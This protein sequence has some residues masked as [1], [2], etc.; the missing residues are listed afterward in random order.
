MRP[1]RE[2]DER[3]GAG[4]RSSARGVVVACVMALACG[5]QPSLAQTPDTHAPAGQFRPPTPA[6]RFR[7]DPSRN[8][9]VHPEGYVPAPPNSLGSVAR[10]GHGP[11]PLVLVAGLGFGGR[12]FDPIVKGL[13]NAY[14]VYV[15]T[16]A[17]Y[18]GSSAPPMP[19]PGTSYGERSWLAGAERGLDALLRKEKLDRPLLAALY[20]DAASV[21]T[22]FARAHPDRVGG[23]LLMSAAARFPLPEGGMSR[24]ER[25][26][27]FANQWFRTV[28]EIMWPS[29]MFT[30]DYYAS[31]PDVAERAWWDVLEPSLPVS[32]RYLVETW[33]DDLVPVVA[34]IDAPVIVLSPAFDFLEGASRERNE[35]R[36]LEGWKAA[37]EQ[38]AGLEHRVVPGARFLIWE[39]APAALDQ[40]LQD[41]SRRRAEGKDVR[42]K[43]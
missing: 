37:R 6:D 22:H 25:M 18:G 3:D 9:L 39:D 26:D 20:S 32:I 12:V 42:L 15:V 28:T 33:A 43:P 13:E 30:P 35:R 40:A 24:A 31:S 38:G 23:V 11:I 7:Q 4:T 14:T 10:H 29:G 16:L 21:V 36:F 27:A 8:N 19:P 5:V 1:A 2:K 41:L 34:A 17:G